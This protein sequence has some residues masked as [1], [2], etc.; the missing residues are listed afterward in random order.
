MD[1]EFFAGLFIDMMF[2][3]RDRTIN[4][5]IQVFFYVSI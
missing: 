5:L 1:K 2:K 3:R 4:P